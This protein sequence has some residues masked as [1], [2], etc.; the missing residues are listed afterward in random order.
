MA[1]LNW[2]TKH[3]YLN[4]SSCR[5]YFLMLIKY[6]LCF[7]D[8]ISFNIVVCVL[9]SHQAIVWKFGVGLVLEK[10]QGSSIIT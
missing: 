4:G 6:A 10:L 7:K 8:F 1:F 2:Y 3:V 5:V 9:K